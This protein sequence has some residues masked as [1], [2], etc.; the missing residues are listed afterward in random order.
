MSSSIISRLFKILV[1]V[2]LALILTYIG[3]NYVVVL[4]AVGLILTILN[5]RKKDAIF[6]GILYAFIGYVM[7]YP[8][9]LANMGQYIP[10]VDIPVQT[11]VLTSFI[12]LLIGVVIPVLVSIILTGSVSIITYYVLDYLNLTK[13]KTNRYEKHYFQTKEAIK[14]NRDQNRRKKEKEDLLN[15]SPIQKSKIK[16]QK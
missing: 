3:I 13:D 7:S 15:L 5:K 8:V 10:L 6:T 14:E 1:A 16:N 12:S 4:L 11:T 2:I 9:G